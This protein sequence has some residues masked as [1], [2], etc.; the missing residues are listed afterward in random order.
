[1]E[2]FNHRLIENPFSNDDI[3]VGIKTLKSKNLTMGTKTAA[4]EKLF[5]KKLGSKYAVMVN[6]GSSANLLA[7]KCITNHLKKKFLKKGD[8]C[9]VPGLCWSTTFWPILQ[10]NLNPKFVDI[11]I[12]NFCIDLKTI[13]KNITK[14][15]KAIFIINVLGNCSDIDEIQKFCK[16]KKII[17]IEDN[18]E[19]LGSI[20]KKKYLGTYGE[21][22]TFSFYC[23]HQ[24][25][26]GEG[27]MIVTNSYENYKILK[28]LRAHGWDRDI[29][30]KNKKI[31]NFI[32]E[33]Y[34]V[35][36]L[37]ISA[38]I[39]MNQ[40]KRIDKLKKVRSQNRDLIIRSLKNSE[41]WRNQF[42]FFDN[43]SSL[44]PSWFGLPLV[45]NEKFANKK[46]KYLNYLNKNKIETRPII[47]GN[48]LNQ[49]CM[50][51]SKFKKFYK[52]LPNTEMVSKRGFFI[53]IPNKIINNKS[54]NIL[55]DKLLKYF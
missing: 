27:G 6:S 35:R 42:K 23:S 9:L 54:L 37:E 26:S 7:L 40:F 16:R 1:M 41:N 53:G 43:D 29:K 4:F 3:K 8:E 5:S 34:N 15:T 46:M 10:S 22:G 52:K 38:S 51:N 30:P 49:V 13:K 33:G 11:N 50:K 39:G 18:C 48:F 44:E 12:N 28:S 31:F 17:L 20:Y 14:K 55:S 36:P 47:S 19:S 45:I 21:L 25:S 24:I 32:N 2:N